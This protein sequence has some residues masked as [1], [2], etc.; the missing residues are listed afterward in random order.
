[1]NNKSK[2]FTELYEAYSAEIDDNRY[3]SE[4]KVVLQKRLGGD[5]HLGRWND[6]HDGRW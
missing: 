4:G 6:K 2:F 3:D 5:N 1:L